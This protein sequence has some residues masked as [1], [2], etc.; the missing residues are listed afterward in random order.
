MGAKILRKL[1]IKEGS[2]VPKGANQHAH[3]AFFKSGDGEP[4]TQGILKRSVEAAAALLKRLVPVAKAVTAAN[5][6]SFDDLLNAADFWEEWW[7]LRGKLQ[8][9]VD[10]IMFSDAADKMARVIQTVEQ[11]ATAVGS[12][13]TDLAGVEKID[14]TLASFLSDELVRKSAFDV[15]DLKKTL[16]LCE[17]QANAPARPTAQE[18]EDTM[19]TLAK[20]L[21]LLAAGEK[22]DAAGQAFVK[23]MGEKAEKVDAL[24]KEAA[25]LK[26]KLAKADAGKCPKCGADLAKAAPA[27]ELPPEAKAL[28]QKETDARVALQKQVDDMQAA[29]AKREVD[30]IVKEFP[31]SG[32][33]AA[34]T[35]LVAAI[36]KSCPA[37]M[38]NL[39]TLLGSVTAAKT[40]ALNLTKELGRGSPAD[41]GSPKGQL[42]ALIKE[43][44]AK[45][46]DAITAEAEAY[47]AHP[48]LEKAIREEERSRAPRA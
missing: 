8:Q 21:A 29:D 16:D 23:E 40:E 35:E 41:A 25:D 7:E 17:A 48:E 27:V 19:L 42:E 15:E 30:A 31:L 34:R 4:P 38:G 26:E 2:F 12:L 39:K 20:V 3:I 43:G 24:T 22:L 36:Q 13:E 11:F 28:L 14:A 37:Q 9:A 1:R 33:V 18:K 6:P 32:E 45:G 47:K 46:K 5:P 44:V 10:G